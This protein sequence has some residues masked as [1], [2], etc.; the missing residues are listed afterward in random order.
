[1]AHIALPGTARFD[2]LSVPYFYSETALLPAQAAANVL[3][4]M[5]VRASAAPQI[6]VARHI[7]AVVSGRKPP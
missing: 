1:M 3:G 4:A 7:S 5:R 2:K 6:F